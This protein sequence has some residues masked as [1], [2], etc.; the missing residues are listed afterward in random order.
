MVAK[1]TEFTIESVLFTSP[2]IRQPV[3]LRLNVTDIDIYES[4]DKPYLT[5]EVVLVDNN[6]FIENADI[7][8]AENITIALKS[9]RTGTNTI[10]KNFYINK[11]TH[12]QR[13]NDN[14]QVVVLHIIEDI[15]HLANLFNVNRYYEGTGSDII[16]KICGEFMG[17]QLT[18]ERTDLQNL[19]LI[20]PNLDPLQAC[21]WIADNL[22][23][24]HGFPYYFYS[25]LV[26]PK[27]VL[28]DLVSLITSVPLNTNSVYQWSQSAV[29]SHEEDVQRR[30]IHSFKL[31]KN[32]EDLF[33][34]IQ[35]GLIGAK[36]SYLD[37]AAD[38]TNVEIQFPF[39]V[40]ED[41]LAP[42]ISSG[43]IPATQN[44]VGY[45]PV[46]K[47]GSTPYNQ[48][49]SRHITQIGGSNPY[50]V[51]KL[52]DESDEIP[53]HPLTIGEAYNDAFYKLYVMR[54]SMDNLLIKSAITINVNGIDFIDGNKHS[55]IGNQLRCRF[56]HSNPEIPIGNRSDWDTKLSGD[57]LI[58]RTR[59]IIKRERYDMA[60]TMVKL[61][62]YPK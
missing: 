32:S 34:V 27:V 12:Q 53:Q 45:S 42:A 47:V 24:V 30:T 41:A 37:T 2:R 26:S 44:N 60:H 25:T 36:Y 50:R 14:S 59:H 3:E 56:Q 16:E 15:L 54:R 51:T 18:T 8:G 1:N 9:A 28:R 19:K 6:N 52:P 21:K 38:N 46:F 49:E 23:S 58:Y 55:T 7:L 13:V 35:K 29:Q 31:G 39:D 10:V 57:Y 5:G 11:I 20:V 22:T 43:A 61:G 40:V 62:S 17:R 33:S 48:M 4:L